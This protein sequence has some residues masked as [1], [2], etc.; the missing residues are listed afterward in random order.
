M[1]L[2]SVIAVDVAE[3]GSCSSD[4]SPSLGT[5][6]C[7]RQSPKEGEIERKKKNYDEIPHSRLQNVLWVEGKNKIYRTNACPEMK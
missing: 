6:I 1:R 7:C 2:R 3:A 4:P 5:S